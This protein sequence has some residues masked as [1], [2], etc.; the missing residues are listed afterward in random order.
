MTIPAQWS[1]DEG[2]EAEYSTSTPGQENFPVVPVKVM[3]TENENVAP[4]F[5]SC[6]TWTVQQIGTASGQQLQVIPRRYRRYKAKFLVTFPGAATLYVNTQ[7]GPL[8]NPTPQGFQYTVQTAGTVPL[9]EYDSMQ[10][11]YMIGSVAGI[12]VSIWDESY[13]EV[14]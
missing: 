6:M 1:E 12:T 5:C 13:G 7:P 8:T 11:L 9:P 4:E 10:P 3:F 14:S 2:N